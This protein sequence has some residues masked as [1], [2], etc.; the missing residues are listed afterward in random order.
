MFNHSNGHTDIVV[1]SYFCWPCLFRLSIYHS[2][3][4]VYTLSPIL[5]SLVCS[6]L[7]DCFFFFDSSFDMLLLSVLSSATCTFLTVRF[8]WVAVFFLRCYFF[9]FY[10]GMLRNQ[11]RFLLFEIFVCRVFTLFLIDHA[12]GRGRKFLIVL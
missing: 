8:R 7:Y 10:D 3:T 6:L 1:T 2:F 12:L 4:I 5:N 9:R 11:G